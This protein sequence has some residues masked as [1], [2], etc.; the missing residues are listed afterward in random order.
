[1]IFY[2]PISCWYI[3][4]PTNLQTLHRMYIVNAGPGFKKMLWPAAQ[5]FLD[6]KTIAKIQVKDMVRPIISHSNCPVA[7]SDHIY[8]QKLQVLEP[9]SLSKL[10]E[11][12]DSR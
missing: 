2:F 8:L 10:L 12:I 3:I 7:F 5:K 6:A 9:K 11:V 1:M 4:V